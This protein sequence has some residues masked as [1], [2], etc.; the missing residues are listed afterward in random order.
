[1][2][3]FRARRNLGDNLVQVLHEETEPLR[4]LNTLAKVMQEVIENKS[5]TILLNKK[6]RALAKFIF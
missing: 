6:R 2:H 3:R 4:G 5:L 1:M